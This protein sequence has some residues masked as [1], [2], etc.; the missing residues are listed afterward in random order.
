MNTVLRNSGYDNRGKCYNGVHGGVGN[1]QWMNNYVGLHPSMQFSPPLSSTQIWTTPTPPPPSTKTRTS[2]PEQ[3]VATAQ[4]FSSGEMKIE[5]PQVMFQDKVDNSSDP[6]LPKLIE[7]P[8]AVEPLSLDGGKIHP[9]KV[10]LEKLELNKFQLNP[11]STI[12][13]KNIDETDV[14]FVQTES[15]LTSLV[16]KLVKC[17]EIAI[18]LEHH[19]YRSYQ[20]I[21][22]LMQI[23][24]RD[25]DYLIDTL[26][27]R[28][29]LHVLNE[30]FTNPKVLKVL[31]GA[32]NDIQWLQRDLSLYIVN[33]FDT[34]QAAI[35]LN[36]PPGQR[37]F[38]NLLSVYCNIQADKQHQQ[39]DWRIR[40]LPEELVKYSRMDTHYLL[41]IKDVMSNKLL[42]LDKGQDN[43]LKFVY[44]KS[45]D[46]CK[47]VYR[48]PI[49]DISSFMY[50]YK[51]SG[52][53]FNEQ[54][55]C[56]LKKLYFWRDKTARREDDSVEYVLPNIM[57]LSIAEKLPNKVED[58]YGCCTPVPPL[59]EK[60]INK[61]YKIIIS[62][63]TD[64]T[65]DYSTK[66]YGNNYYKNSHN[67]NNNFIINNN[68]IYSENTH[69]NY[70]HNNNNNN[71]Y[72][73]SNININYN[74]S[75][76]N[77]YSGQQIHRHWN[78]PVIYAAMPY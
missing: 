45:T 13:Y 2:P 23:S 16:Q 48:K 15:E 68:N 44:K 25:T 11:S 17:C 56:A 54:Q 3:S 76:I 53:K 4:Q 40:P 60:N 33:M 27:L 14:V 34:H 69:N 58:I 1:W 73:N 72:Y 10:E 37:S 43:K 61:L 28:S 38:A 78:P 24:T 26:S 35:A 70:V 32:D 57:M 18:D 42:I 8:N 64:E 12:M 74:D 39:A 36:I 65:C 63:K 19:S 30:V 31:H 6:W 75:H 59:V 9:Y 66:N 50:F 52:K 55:L 62:S 51:K 21:T 67:N 5:K 77:N 22:C 49:C 71:S 47:T 7:K 20:G 29:D 46:I 41:Y